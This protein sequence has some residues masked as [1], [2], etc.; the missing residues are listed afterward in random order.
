M[1]KFYTTLISL[2]IISAGIKAQTQPQKAPVS[3][4]KLSFQLQ[5]G[6]QGVGGDLRYGLNQQISVR[7][8]ASFIPVKANNVF[9]F[10]GFESTNNVSVKFSNVHLWADFVPFK[11][12]QG[13]RLVAG[14]GYLFQANGDIHVLPT[15]TYTVGNYKLTPA[16]LGTLKIDMSWKGVA[17][18]A[19]FGLF[20]SFPNHRFNVNL[21]L[22]TYY[23]SQPKSNIVGTEML[24]DNYK[25]EPQ[26]NANMKSYRWLPV[27][28][29][30]F[31]F[32]IR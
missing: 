4:T 2:L 14:A 22:G 5:A 3:D 11:K 15:G 17:P 25:L 29:L 21:D 24:A 12:A 23:L 27:A 7:G 10:S 9:S 18:Y 31:N 26:L 13:F 8:G 16:D 30:N 20:K 1:N 32:R 19:G 28:Q 6:T